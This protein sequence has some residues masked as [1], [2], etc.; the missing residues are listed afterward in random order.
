MEIQSSKDKIIII[1]DSTQYLFVL[2]K[3]SLLIQ[4]FFTVIPIYIMGFYGIFVAVAVAIVQF[5]NYFF[6]KRIEFIVEKM[7]I[8]K[9]KVEIYHMVNSKI[10]DQKFFYFKDIQRVYYEEGF[11]DRYRKDFTIRRTAN[12]QRFIKIESQKGKFAFGYRISE[13][14]GN[15]VL[16]SFSHFY[17][18]YLSNQREEQKYNSQKK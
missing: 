17:D 14:E 6:E 18:L 8:E 15:L 12:R 7:V 10:Q 2:K 11:L 3:W 5:L 1:Q 4:V 13:A 16:N 9:E